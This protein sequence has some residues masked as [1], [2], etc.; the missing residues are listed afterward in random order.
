[1]IKA[2]FIDYTGT[3]V[4]EDEPYTRELVKYFITHSDLKDPK[5]VLGVVWT[6]VKE[7]EAASFGKDFIKNDDKVDIILDYCEKTCGLKGD[8]GYMHDTWRKIW[9]HAP[10]YGDVRPFFERVKVP[11]YIISN[12]D[13]MYLEESM[14]IKDLHPAGIISAETVGACKPHRSIF[15][16]ALETA[17]VK[18]EEAVFIGDSVTSDVKPALAMGITPVYL[19]RNGGDAPEGVRVI[20][21]LDE[22]MSPC[23][24]SNSE[25]QPCVG[26]VLR[27]LASIAGDRIITGQHTQTMDMEELKH[28]RAVTGKAPG[29]LGFELL[30]YSPNI[31]KQDTDE[32][33]MTEVAENRGTLQRALEW[34]KEKGLITFTWH[35]FSPLGGRSKSFFTQNTDFDASKAVLPG[36]P[37]NEALI[38]DMD[39]MAKLLEPFCEKGIPVLWRP[40][41]EMD[42]D[43][44]W[45]GAKGA[46][47]AKKLW[48]IMY[49]RYTSH[50]HLTNLIW[51]WNAE[52]AQYYPG[53]EFVDVISRDM[54]PPAH[55]H[56]AR[57]EEY[58][59]MEKVTTAPKTVLIGET[60]VLPDVKELHDKKVGWASYMTWSKVF[61]LTEEYNSGEEL[62]KL[63]DSPYAI[64]L[65]DIR[66]QKLY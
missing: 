65:E 50:H 59:A 46:E 26:R 38:Y 13:L 35:W 14:R 51:E 28:I 64:T 52:N 5:A 55:E 9:V 16:R 66:E 8:R 22:Y 34:A 27:Y 19:A 57:K 30:S 56:T 47:T 44:F 36:T 49:E 17:G 62:K 53:D 10:L 12:D 6:K 15:E 25:A 45:W 11:V 33:C 29:L 31:N 39:H 60:G 2:I 4:M 40:F 41:H 20:R 32:E 21:S 54:Y 3:M 61:C 7:L 24:P 42:G 58:I 1:M 37:E 48:K 18:P 63:Y 43:W 23:V